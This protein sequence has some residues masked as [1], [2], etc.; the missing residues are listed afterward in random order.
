MNHI[1]VLLL[2][3]CLWPVLGHEQDPSERIKDLERQLAEAKA[4]L[5]SLQKTMESLSSEMQSLRQPGRKPAVNPS[6]GG[7]S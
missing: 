7:F 6:P 2:L 5:A 3:A 1:T 4:R